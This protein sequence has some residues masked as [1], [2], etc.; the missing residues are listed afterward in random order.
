MTFLSKAHIE[1]KREH[2]RA[3]TPTGRMCSVSV[4]DDTD[5]DIVFDADGVCNHVHY[6]RRR[7]ANERFRG[8]EAEARLTQA[9]QRIKHEGKGKTYDCVLGV[10]GGVDSTYAAWRAKELGLRPLAVHLDNGWNSD[11]A[12][13]NIERVLS[14]LDIDL[15]THV[16]DWEEIKDLQRSVILSGT[17]NLEVVSD[18][19]INATMVRQAAKHGIRTIVTGVNV[20]TES[21]HLSKWHYDNRD[22]HFIRGLHKRFGSTKLRTYPTISAFDL[23]WYLFVRRIRTLPV[24][25]YAE[26]NKEKV[27]QLLQ[28]ELGWQPYAHKHGE[29]V[30]T[31]FFQEYY[32]PEKWGFDK[33]KLH[34]STLIVSG[35]MTRDEALEKL[36][37]PLYSE[38][39]QEDELAYV[40]KKLGFSTQA[41]DEVMASE[42]RYFFDYPNSAWMFDY[43]N[44][45]VQY[46]RAVGKGERRILSLSPRA[47]S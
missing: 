26:Y 35:Q 30:Y 14:A 36:E 16:V 2:Y 31:R 22:A 34:F 6:A 13:S 12:V 47:Q 7:L 8:P 1:Q 3:H 21:M 28:D 33:R 25:N 24:L 11:L 20:E 29:S 10:S 19:A 27:K 43:D 37:E 42:R 4:M 41:W 15:H 17:A 9:V 45:L 38:G 40:T 23:A 5:P 39:E 46:V 18:H 32:L 44:P